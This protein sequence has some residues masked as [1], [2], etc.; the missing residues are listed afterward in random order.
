MW[1]VGVS[2]WARWLPR[3]LSSAPRSWICTSPPAAARGAVAGAVGG[4]T[5]LAVTRATTSGV[6]SRAR[7]STCACGRVQCFGVDVAV[8]L[9]A[10][11]RRVGIRDHDGAWVPWR[12]VKL[13]TYSQ[14]MLG[15]IPD[16][17]G[18]LTALVYA[19]SLCQCL[20]AGGHGCVSC[21]VYSVL[22]RACPRCFSGIWTSATTCCRVPSHQRW[23]SSPRSRTLCCRSSTATATATPHPHPL[24][25]DLRWSSP[26]ESHADCCTCCGVNWLLLVSRVRHAD[27]CWWCR[28]LFL[29]D[30]ELS[31]E[32]PT[33]LGR[34]TALK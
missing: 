33:A 28:L 11:C 14:N 19:H 24:P 17:I 23:A 15:T 26:C 4:T 10:P 25:S 13:D 7:A 31:G 2:E 18:N 27:W 20:V 3:P 16:S 1:R 34:L 5:L 21:Y 6:Q 32:I 30:N 8:R 9:L 12:S 22:H 29:F